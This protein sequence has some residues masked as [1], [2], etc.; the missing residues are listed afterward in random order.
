MKTILAAVDLARGSSAVCAAAARLARLAGARLV[1]LHVAEPPPVEL[2]GVGFAQAQV[3]GMLAALRQRA[4]RRLHALARRWRCAGGPVQV[5]EVDGRSVPEILA[6]ARAT[7]A[8]CI[9]LGSHGHGAAYDL[10]VGSTAHGVLRASTRPVLVV[11]VK[12]RA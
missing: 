12:T 10:L 11:P 5:R 3:R 8:A 4:T 6:A 9:V 7:R 1:I 2:H